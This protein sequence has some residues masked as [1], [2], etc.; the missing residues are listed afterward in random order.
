MLFRSLRKVEAGA[1]V[2]VFVHVT[3]GD[4]AGEILALA[5]D[6]QA[7]LILVGTHGR[8]GL[9][10]LL[11]GSVAE[12]VVRNAT[13]PV[14]VMRPRRYDVHPELAPEPACPE[15][16]KMREASGGAEWWCEPHRKPWTRPHRYSYRDGDL[17]PYHPDGIG[18]Q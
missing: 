8:Q 7:D 13:C 16:V 12:Q 14:L 15:C 17:H 6:V 11:M 10:R 9:K 2:R 18:P 4:P 5:E 3:H 1:T